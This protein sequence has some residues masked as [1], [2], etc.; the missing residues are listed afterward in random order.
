VS[1]NQSQQT[2]MSLQAQAT[3]FKNVV[4]NN[5]LACLWLAFLISEHNK[6]K[7]NRVPVSS[8]FKKLSE[9]KDYL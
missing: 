6:N 3:I 1:H 5:T 9:F 4:N 2:Q 7:L 8:H